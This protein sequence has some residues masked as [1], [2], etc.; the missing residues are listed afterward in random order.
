MA[1]FDTKFFESLIDQLSNDIGNA[2]SARVVIPVSHIYLEFMMRLILEKR[3]SKEEFENLDKDWNFGFKKKLDKLNSMG[4]F[5]DDE[6][7]DLDII[8]WIR[9]QLTHNFKADLFDIHDKVLSLHF[10]KF[11]KNRNPVE[12]V[13][14]DVLELMQKLEQK[15]LN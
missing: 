1:S 6:Y 10:H 13:L 9:N 7:Y 5:S 2:H 4:E 14:Y 15:Y 12:V 11:N 3:L 8:N